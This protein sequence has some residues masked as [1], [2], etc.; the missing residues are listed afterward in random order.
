MRDGVLG[1]L[2]AFGAGECELTVRQL[3]LV[4]VELVLQWGGWE[5]ALPDCGS[6][7]LS[8]TF[9]EFL[10]VLAEEA[11]SEHG[12]PSMSRHG[13]SAYRCLAGR[14]SRLPPLT[15]WMAGCAQSWQG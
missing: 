5:T 8:S 13:L 10:Q 11:Q 6:R 7:L 14:L 1:Q 9:H 3:C 2:Q 4:L 12:P 15:D